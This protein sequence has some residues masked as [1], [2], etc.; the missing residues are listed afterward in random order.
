MVLVFGSLEDLVI[1]VMK[2]PHVKRQRPSKKYS[3][4][5]ETANN[6][7]SPGLAAYAGSPK[8]QIPVLDTLL[9]MDWLP[10]R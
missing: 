9:Y 7:Q 10:T 3:S 8:E 6:N 2:G 1:A 4:F 5:V